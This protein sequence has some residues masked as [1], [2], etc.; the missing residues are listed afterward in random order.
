MGNIDF[1]NITLLDGFWKNRYEL[2][3]N[4]SI[5]SIENRF[6]DTR[7][8]AMLFGFK[9]EETNYHHVA[10]DSD[11]AKLME[12]MSYLLSKNREKYA[13][14]EDFCEKIIDSIESHQ[15]KNGYFNS[16][17]LLGKSDAI[18]TKREAHELYCLGHLIEAAIAYKNA[19]GKD[20]FLGLCIKYLKYVE[21]RFM[22]NQDT[23]FL[24]PGHEEIELALLRLYRESKNKKYL[25][26]ASFFLE[27]R[28]N[29]KIDSFEFYGSD[30]Y[31]QDNAPIRKLKSVEGHAV[32]AMYLLDAM[33]KYALEIN[34]S[35]LKNTLSTL[36]NDLVTK[37]YISGGIGS[38]RIGEI[39]TIP[40]D[41]PN[42]TA[43]NE[44]CA[45][46]AEMFFLNDMF[47]LEQNKKYHDNLERILYNGF[48]S[49]TSINGKA[50]FYENPLEI[51]LKDI[52]KETSVRPEWRTKLP[53]T[54]RVELFDCSCCPPNIARFIASI[55]SYIYHQKENRIYINQFISSKLNLDSVT[56]KMESS[57]PREFKLKLSIEA[58]EDLI[59]MIRVPEYANKIYINGK[60]ISKNNDYIELI[61]KNG[62]CNYSI[63]FKTDIRLMQAHPSN[64]FD[65]NKVALMYGPILYC[66]EAIDNGEDLN[67]LTLIGSKVREK[68]FDILYEMNTFTMD[69]LRK[70]PSKE[71]YSSSYE[72]TE[73]QLRFIPYCY[74][75]NR[76]KTDM[77][78]WIN[79][80]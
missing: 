15:D 6:K 75:A 70:L 72:Y 78:V 33:A 37:Q 45:S 39:L 58:K 69:G 35:E 17:F 38:Y 66:L 10:Y 40:Y 34:D 5:P 71:P 54:E 7:I 42:L 46:I 79:N 32:R 28:G 19:T 14:Y 80:K 2:N 29:N 31:T 11:V 74:F 21:K 22:Q 20:R 4:V 3:A 52:D 25:D 47:E 16:Y 1:K 24:T 59:L 41:T 27:K 61:I 30:K 64:P 73:Q 23:A 60:N 50:F 67:A 48:L 76:G 62:E 13:S 57:Y 53:I 49:S 9:E 8:K 77:L 44:S 12:A 68:Q 63:E 51:R 18:F 56:I 36:Y 65:Q 43:Y 55:G 26:M